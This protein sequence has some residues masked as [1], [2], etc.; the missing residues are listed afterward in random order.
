MF[1]ADLRIDGYFSESKFLNKSKR[2]IVPPDRSSNGDTNASTSCRGSGTRESPKRTQKVTK[3]EIVT[4]DASRAASSPAKKSKAS[5]IIWDIEVGKSLSR[6][7]SS[8]PI[9]P[10][11]RG[12]VVVDTGHHAW[13]NVLCEKDAE[14]K[15]RPHEAPTSIGPSQSASQGEVVSSAMPAPEKGTRSKYFQTREPSTL[16]VQDKATTEP[17]VSLCSSNESSIGMVQVPPIDDH[18]ENTTCLDNIMQNGS[19]DGGS[20]FIQNELEYGEH[21]QA[22]Q[23]SLEARDHDL[24]IGHLNYDEDDVLG[25]FAIFDEYQD[26][27]NDNGQ[28]VVYDEA[29]FVDQNSKEARKQISD[30]HASFPGQFELNGYSQEGDAYCDYFNDAVGQGDLEIKESCDYVLGEKM[31]VEHDCTYDN[32]EP[33]DSYHDQALGSVGRTDDDS[34]EEQDAFHTN[35][36]SQGRALLLGCSTESTQGRATPSYRASAEVDVVKHL[37]DHWLPQKL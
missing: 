33:V 6:D 32:E 25:D 21:I 37:R 16:N 19:H 35:R 26:L 36:F 27:Q 2:E 1:L 28:H 30:E 15:G 34:S 29:L 9:T 4:C 14:K 5:S 24:H 20:E 17:L 31:V 12:S 13:A 11:K 3:A 23:F 8:M 7:D 22:D 18:A 10:T